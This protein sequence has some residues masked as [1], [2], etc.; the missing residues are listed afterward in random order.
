MADVLVAV[1]TDRVPVGDH[2]SDQRRV[3]PR[4]GSDREER[5]AGT[6]FAEHVEQARRRVRIGTIIKRQGEPR[7]Q[8]PLPG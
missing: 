2:P 3:R 4:A 1:K 8:Y 6:G 5:G 7:H